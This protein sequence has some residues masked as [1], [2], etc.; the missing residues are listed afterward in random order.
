M[1]LAVADR[2][3]VRKLRHAARMTADLRAAD[4]AA[5]D[6]LAGRAQAACD[7]LLAAAQAGYRPEDGSSGA[8]E[9]E[10]AL[11]H[12]IADGVR[13]LRAIAG[14]SAVVDGVLADPDRIDDA[15]RIV[16]NVRDA[17]A[18][19]PLNGAAERFRDAARAAGYDTVAEIVEAPLGGYAAAL[20]SGGADV[21]ELDAA[22]H[23]L[24]KARAEANR[25]L[26]AGR[27]YVA[28]KVDAYPT[29][30]VAFDEVW[31]VGDLGDAEAENAALDDVGVAEPEDEV[32]EDD[33]FD[34][35]DGD[36]G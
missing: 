27:S 6:C 14:A 16:G 26:R 1:N 22:Q 24:V 25:W 4:P 21:E 18:G 2:V 8:K 33:G 10:Q 29:C 19:P 34:G 12:A 13:L 17:K 7:E 20:E 32:A 35:E 28:Y 5:E 11:R 30:G 23:R 3:R 15:E 36:E 9:A 31:P